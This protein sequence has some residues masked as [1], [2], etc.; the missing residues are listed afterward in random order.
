MDAIFREYLNS[1][2]TILT[3][4]KHMKSARNIFIATVY[5]FEFFILQKN[6]DHCTI[7]IVMFLQQK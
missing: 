7:V 2:T 1:L 4:F 6:I 3:T 5:S